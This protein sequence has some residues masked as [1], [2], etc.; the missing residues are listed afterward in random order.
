MKKTVVL[1]SSLLIIVSTLVAQPMSEVQSKTEVKV[2]ILPKFEVGEM[3]GDFP[4]EAQYYF[5]AYVKNG[6]VYDID[7]GFQGN[8]LYVKDGVALYVTGMGKVNTAVSLQAV[9]S[10]DRFD[11]SDCYVMSTGCAGSAKDYGVMGDVFVITATVD[12]DLGHHADIR[13]LPEGYETTWFHDE[14][15]D[16]SSYKILDQELA[17]KVYD[18]VKDVKIETTPKTKAFMSAAFDGA[19]WATR[20]PKVLRGTTVSGDNYWKGVYDHANALLMVETYGCPD[21]YALTEMEDV[22]LGVVLDRYGMLDRY[23]IIRDSVNMD[24]FMNGATAASLW[25]PEFDSSLASED[26]VEAADI[27]M[28]AMENNYKVGAVVVDAILNDTL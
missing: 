21:P 6:E 10:D 17:G 3:S 7:G 25:D 28:T 20:D 23:I 15:Y 1:F 8:K 4:G 16:S 13:D 11:F 2:L 9:L 19:E 5:D 18:L 22:A 12:Y 26:S 24:V 27:F 14:G